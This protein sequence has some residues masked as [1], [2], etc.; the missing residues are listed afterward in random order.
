[1]NE[2]EMEIKLDELE[3]DLAEQHCR[4][5]ALAK[6]GS[7]AIRRRLDEIERVAK[8]TDKQIE[9]HSTMLRGLTIPAS[10]PPRSIPETAADEAMEV[11][12]TSLVRAWRQRAVDTAAELERVKAVNA[13]LVEALTQIEEYWNRNQNNTAM[14]DALWR[15]VEVAAAAI[16]KAPDAAMGEGEVKNREGQPT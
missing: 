14:A 10:N 2:H 11:N 7:P 13:E 4:I 12:A 6:C 1:M 8:I 9:V 16:A 3:T 5:D 15:M